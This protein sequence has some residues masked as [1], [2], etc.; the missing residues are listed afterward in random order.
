MKAWKS[1]NGFGATFQ[2]KLLCAKSCLGVSTYSTVLISGW[3]LS[4]FLLVW[5]I[6]VNREEVHDQLN[7]T[8]DG[9]FLVRRATTHATKGDYTLTLR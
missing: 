6:F 9:T 1:V 3:V 5:Y 4:G 8:P 2:S 7:G